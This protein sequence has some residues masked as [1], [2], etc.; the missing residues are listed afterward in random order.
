MYSF[1]EGLR[2][3]ARKERKAAKLMAKLGKPRPEYAGTI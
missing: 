3:T 2:K 1:I